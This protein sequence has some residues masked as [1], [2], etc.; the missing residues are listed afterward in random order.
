MG[1]HPF[2]MAVRWYL[3]MRINHG[4][5]ILILTKILISVKSVSLVRSCDSH[6]CHM[7]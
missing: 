2:V 3:I 7:I 6:Q 5:E 1:P 4:T